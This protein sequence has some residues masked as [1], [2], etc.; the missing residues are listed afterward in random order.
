[1]ATDE[2][3]GTAAIRLAICS[4]A[5]STA[6]GFA[7][8]DSGMKRRSVWR[9]SGSLNPGVTCLRA[10]NVRIISPELTRSTRASA[11]WMTTSVLR[12]RRRSRLSLSARPPA[13]SVAVTCSPAWRSAGMMP[14]SNPAPSEM[15]SVNS[16]TVPSMA[17]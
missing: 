8:C 6:S 4:W 1:M 11:T 5:W 7:I 14:N 16:R 13:R 15:T 10:W 17:I 9:C 12:A 2:T 3:P